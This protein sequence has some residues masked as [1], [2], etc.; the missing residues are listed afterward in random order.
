[1]R[2]PGLPDPRSPEFLNAVKENVEIITGR[3]G[4][5]IAPLP[6]SATLPDVITKL[7]ELIDRLQ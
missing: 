7:N 6:T 2:K 3:R 4:G 1:M 5:K